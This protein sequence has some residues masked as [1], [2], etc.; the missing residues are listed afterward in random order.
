[1]VRSGFT[2]VCASLDDFI[3]LHPIGDFPKRH[4]RR[5]PRGGDEFA[6]AFRIGERRQ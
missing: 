6:H 3:D 4:R 5:E 2:G 1:V